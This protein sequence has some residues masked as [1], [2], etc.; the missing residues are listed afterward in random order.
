M[1]KLR[2]TQTEMSYR[3]DSK[4]E[5]RVTQAGI[6]KGEDSKLELRVPQV[7]PLFT[8]GKQTGIASHSNRNLPTRG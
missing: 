3:E 5:L 7:E 8:R 2:I 1:H 4:L 6:C